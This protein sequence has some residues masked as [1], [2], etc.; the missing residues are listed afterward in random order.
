M[1]NGIWAALSGANVQLEAL[2]VAANN[3]ANAS[4]PGYRGDHAVFR[5]HLGRA[6]KAAAAASQKTRG[7]PTSLRY[8]TMD[9]VGTNGTPGAFV[10]TG[11]PLDVAIHG[12]GM[13]VLGTARGIRYTRLGSIQVAKD[14]KLV[15]KD[16]DLFLNRD[17]KP[18]AVP[19]GVTDVRI[20]T[21]GTVHAAGEACGQLVLVNFKNPTGLDR[22]GAL[23]FKA[24]PASGAPRLSTATLEGESLEQSNV[25]VVRG[26]VDIVGASRGFEACERAIDAF[27]DA[28]RRAAMALMGKD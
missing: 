3:V 10:A 25:S 2:D 1:G 19:P 6:S 11:R 18:V 26:M 27:R 23:V 14:G 5:E 16:G 7:L 24:T 28:D 12:D 13:F 21:D 20:G 17:N 9:G 22:E 4:T 15:T 8:S